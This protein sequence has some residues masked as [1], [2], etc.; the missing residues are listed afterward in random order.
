MI[1]N[2]LRSLSGDG[3]V[4]KVFGNDYETDDGTCVRYVHVNDLAQAHLLGLEFMEKSRFN[5]FNLKRFWLFCIGNVRRVLRS[6]KL[7]LH[8]GV[9][10][11]RI[12]DPAWLI[13]K[14]LF[15]SRLGPQY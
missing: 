12:G 4:L 3:D 2:I 9:H 8:L 5:A 10:E 13:V 6:L 14:L 15:P 1:P 7:K 11:R